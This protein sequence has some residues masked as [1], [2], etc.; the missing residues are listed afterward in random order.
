MTVGP[1]GKGSGF[2]RFYPSTWHDLRSR[3]NRGPAFASH[4][5]STGIMDPKIGQDHGRI[6][7]CLR[8][9]LRP[10]IGLTM[11]LD[12]GSVY[13]PPE[14]LWVKSVSAICRAVA[15]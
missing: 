7:K 10:Q 5:I 3:C 2:A 15:R 11:L 14:D 4:L 8:G 6:L 1:A 12:V 9:S 13:T